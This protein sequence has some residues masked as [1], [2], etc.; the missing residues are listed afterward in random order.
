MV[1][2]MGEPHVAYEP[3]ACAPGMR[4]AAHE[5]VSQIHHDNLNRRLDRL[6]DMME[7]LERRLW[8]TVY[9]VV[10]VILAQAAQS[11]IVTTP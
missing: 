1:A 5:R 11:F 6:E 2:W 4:L 3:F 10:A 9:G 7:R 8:L